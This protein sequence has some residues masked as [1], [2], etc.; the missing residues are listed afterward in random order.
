MAPYICHVGGHL[1]ITGEVDGCHDE[2]CLEFATLE[3][4]PAGLCVARVSGTEATKISRHNSDTFH[5][6]M[7]AYKDAVDQGVSPDQITHKAAETALK[8]AEAVS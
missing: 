7:Y 4:R 8:E 5:R 2:S 6:D 3:V 1:Y